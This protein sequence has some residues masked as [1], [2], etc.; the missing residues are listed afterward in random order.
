MFFI[1]LPRSWPIANQNLSALDA[2]SYLSFVMDDGL[3][4]SF[5]GCLFLAKPPKNSAASQKS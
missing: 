1:S 2:I 5:A 3:T 4:L